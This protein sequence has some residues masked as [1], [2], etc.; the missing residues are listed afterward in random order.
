VVKPEKK[1][2]WQDP[3]D[4]QPGTAEPPKTAEKP[5]Q[6]DPLICNQLNMRHAFDEI[7]GVLGREFMAK[8]VNDMAA[9]MG[10]LSKSFN[11]FIGV[12]A[13]DQFREFA[14]M[15]LAFFSGAKSYE[16]AVADFVR[17]H[18]L[19]KLGDPGLFD[20]HMTKISDELQMHWDAIK[21]ETR[22]ARDEVKKA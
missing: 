5:P 22:R 19:E 15:R 6:V 11:E 8:L 1:S 2:P 13:P 18:P 14:L 12:V 17:I 10:P 9:E 3:G 21:R 7:C 4:L 16:R 20:A